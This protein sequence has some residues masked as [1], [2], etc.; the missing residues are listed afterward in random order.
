[1]ASK[2]G[3]IVGGLA[4]ATLVAAE[5]YLASQAAKAGELAQGAAGITI[6]GLPATITAGQQNVPVTWIVTN[7]SK[8]ADL[9]QAPYTFGSVACVVTLGATAIGTFAFT[10]VA[11]TAGQAIAFGGAT[12]YPATFNV[13]GGAGGAGLVTVTVKDASGATV[14]S[15]TQPFTVL[16]GAITPGATITF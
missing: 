5:I 7:G 9:T 2:T 8:Y 3:L 14:A 1:M 10:T 4:L 12:P 11:F 13:P 16:S 15:G 6:A